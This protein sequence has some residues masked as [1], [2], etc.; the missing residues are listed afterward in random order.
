MAAWLAL[1][2]LRSAGAVVLWLAALLFMLWAAWRN[3]RYADM[4]TRLA[5]PA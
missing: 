4:A 2:E 5:L 1:R 3:D